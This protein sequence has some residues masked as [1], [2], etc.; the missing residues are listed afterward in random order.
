[1][2]AAERFD[3]T[4]LAELRDVVGEPL[5]RVVAKESASLDERATAFIGTSPFVVVASTNGAGESD[6][7][8][9][10][11]P[12]GFVRVIDRQRVVL[13]EYPGNRRLDGVANVLA[14]PGV[15]LL[16]IVPGISE[17]LR[18]NGSA[19]LSRDPELLALCEVDGRRPWFVVDVAVRQVFSHCGKAFLRSA[20]WSPESWPDP[21][22]VV[23]PSLTIAERSREEGLPEQTVR[24]ELEQSYRP[25]LY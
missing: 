14:Y 17:T 4:S 7:S 11:G 23:S 10:G 24:E 22:G 19:R 3:V 15:G 8:P 21:A 13:P 2:D 18:V 6:A 20:L 12:P 25:I 5:A 9:R 16:F 1:V